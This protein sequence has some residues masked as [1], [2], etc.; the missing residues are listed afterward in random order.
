MVQSLDRALSIL[1]YLS[2]RKS[3]GVTEIAEVFSIDKSTATR[4]MQTFAAHD[5]VEKD[6]YTQKYHMSNGTLQLSYQVLLNNRIVQIAR[7]ELLELARITK[8]T[9]RLCAIS[10]DHI[11]ILEQVQ[12]GNERFLQ[13]ADIPGTRKPFHCSAI[14]KVMMAYMPE[15]E[16]SELLS[17]LDFKQY[18]EN[19]ICDVEQ[20]RKQLKEIRIQGYAL[21][22]AEYADRAHCVAVPVFDEL[23]HPSY[24]IG[25]SGMIDYLQQPER[26][27]QIL[28]C[29]QQSAKKLSE[30][31][32]YEFH[33]QR[34]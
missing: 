22:Q 14:G 9:A 31:Y 18:T 5:I 10:R 30:K 34:Y 33:K 29:M 8:E 21:N 25:F 28:T 16:L 20:L 32:C 17:R 6:D 3:M 19:T 2:K 7:P 1:E 27:H 13:N 11:Y 26:F 23:G 4:I 24:S 15:D 12:S